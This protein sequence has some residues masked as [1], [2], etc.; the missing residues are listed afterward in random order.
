MLLSSGRW[1]GQW[2][3]GSAS[4]PDSDQWAHVWGA[5]GPGGG[6]ESLGDGGY[7]RQAGDAHFYPKTPQLPPTDRFMREL[8]RDGKSV[9]LSEYGIGSLFDVIGEWRGF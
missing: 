3:I 1:D 5:E 8:G 2:A 9:F 4:N 7:V 6:K